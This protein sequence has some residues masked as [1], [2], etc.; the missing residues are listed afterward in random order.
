[1]VDPSEEVMRKKTVGFG[2][3]RPCHDDYGAGGVAPA[4]R[5]APDAAIFTRGAREKISTSKVLLTGIILRHEAVGRSE[6][7][8]QEPMARKARQG[9]QQR[10][11]RKNFDEQSAANGDSLS[12]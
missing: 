11:A 2:G 5:A 4:G 9:A 7:R 3:F 1:M 12:P 6:A 8:A 10:R